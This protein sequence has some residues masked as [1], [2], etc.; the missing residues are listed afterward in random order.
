M[1]AG[2]RIFFGTCT[3]ADSTL[4]N[5][6]LPRP[7]EGLQPFQGVEGLGFRGVSL[8]VQGCRF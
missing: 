7:V 2:P 3:G 6:V 5:S 4:E 8:R 1:S